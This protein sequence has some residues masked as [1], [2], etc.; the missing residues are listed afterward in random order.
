MSQYDY[1]VNFLIYTQ[2]VRECTCR[3]CDTTA[4]EGAQ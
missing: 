4:N 2:A 1:R 3:I